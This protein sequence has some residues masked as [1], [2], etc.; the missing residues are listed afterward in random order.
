MN[1]R[2]W[3][4]TRKGLIE[5]RRRA[6]RWAVEQVSFLGEPVTMVLPPDPGSQNMLAC[7]S[8]GHYGTKV[9]A[10]S[11][12]G[13]SWAEI[14]APAYPEQPAD[15]KGPPWKLVQ[16]WSIEQAHGIV[17][18]GTL[19]GGLFRSDDFGRTWALQR[20]LWDRPERLEW[21]GG[22]YDV[23]GIH[24]ICPH[25]GDAN[26]LLLGISCGGAWRS[27]DGGQRWALAAKGMKA[28]FMPPEQADSENIQDPHRIVRSPAAPEL[29]WCQHHGGIWK[30]Q[31]NAASWQRVENVPVSDFGFAV[32]AHPTQADTA[33]FA[34]AAADQQR[35]P[36]GGALV[37]NRTR[38]GGKSFETLRDGLPQED[39][40]DLVY[41]HGLA[42]SADGDHLL[43][44]ST[45]GG[46]WASSDGGD[47]WSTVSN[48]LPPIYAVRLG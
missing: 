35:V 3:L 36:K 25:P 44:A 38:D 17:W 15:A 1:D 47:R 42:V 30:S 31:N 6:G 8:T 13:S 21:F 34:P 5:L 9:H 20:S 28:D 26:D 37:V 43:M 48:L 19:P 16:I 2:A 24:S 12:A 32:A 45:T 41:R 18:A 14:D 22:G 11:D 27:T 7:L 33:W 23:P 40:Y 46:L 4:A 29:L 10:S 39:C